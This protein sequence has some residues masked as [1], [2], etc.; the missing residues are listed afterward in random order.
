[1]MKSHYS[2]NKDLKV[3]TE[4][5][6]KITQSSNNDKR[7]QHVHTEQKK[8]KSEFQRNSLKKDVDAK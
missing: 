3:Y 5:V 7:L 1:M 2:H 4:Q 8:F 6:D